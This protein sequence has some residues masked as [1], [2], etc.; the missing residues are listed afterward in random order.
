MK[1]EKE[2]KTFV[3]A[4]NS[5][6]QKAKCYDEDVKY[7][8]DTLYRERRRHADCEEAMIIDPAEVSKVLRLELLD[9][10]VEHVEKEYN[11]NP[12]VDYGELEAFRTYTD[13]LIED[14]NTEK[15]VL[16]KIFKLFIEHFNRPSAC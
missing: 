10:I 5:M 9:K 6:L 14:T 3:Y 1:T 7:L 8:L 2:I 4:E 12:F 13:N 11:R 15:R 16:G